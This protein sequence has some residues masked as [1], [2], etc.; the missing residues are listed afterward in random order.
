MRVLRA[1]Q[2]SRN[3][4]SWRLSTRISTAN[5]AGER[6]VPFIYPVHKTKTIEMKVGDRLDT[7]YKGIFVGEIVM[8]IVVLL[9]LIIN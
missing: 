2:C 8:G 3:T 7:F 6:V 1:L 9:I 4:I 5:A